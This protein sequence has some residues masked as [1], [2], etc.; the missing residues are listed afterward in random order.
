[1]NIYKCCTDGEEA[2]FLFCIDSTLNPC[3]E[4]MKL[5]GSF[6]DCR[7]AQT[8]SYHFLAGGKV[9][10][11]QNEVVFVKIIKMKHKKKARIL[12]DLYIRSA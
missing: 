4:L 9:I 2:V 8:G 7:I 6:T 11:E 3:T 12:N 10:L 5:Q 1:M